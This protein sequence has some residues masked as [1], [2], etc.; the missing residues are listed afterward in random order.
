MDK[1]EFRKER[2]ASFASKASPRQS[3]AAI[4]APFARKQFMLDIACITK[5]V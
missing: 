2:D 1:C 5:S 4:S 3:K